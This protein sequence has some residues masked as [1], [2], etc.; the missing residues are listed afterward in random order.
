ML[1]A[2]LLSFFIGVLSGSK[3]PGTPE[4]RPEVETPTQLAVTQVSLPPPPLPPLPLPPLPQAPTPVSESTPGA[5][6]QGV[7]RSIRIEW[8]SDPGER[9]DIRRILHGCLG[10]SLAALDSQDRLIAI[11]GSNTGGFSQYGRRVIQPMNQQDDHFMRLHPGAERFVRLYPRYLDTRL[12]GHFGVDPDDDGPLDITGRFRRLGNSLMM[13]RMT[14]N[15]RVSTE[16]VV[17]FAGQC[18]PGAA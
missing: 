6:G 13:T 8:P 4:A 15:G 5:Q 3:Q 14:V 10:V 2:F 12:F 18:R 7:G 11:E 16:S 17:L 9:H 1:L